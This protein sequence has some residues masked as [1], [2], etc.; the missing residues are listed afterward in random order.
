MLIHRNVEQHFTLRTRVIFRL[1]Q[2][3]TQIFIVSDR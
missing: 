2:C 1:A 3:I